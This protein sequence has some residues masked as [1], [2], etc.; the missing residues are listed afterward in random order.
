M[1]KHTFFAYWGNV[2]P[3]MLETCVAS[4]RNVSDCKIHI[5]VN[6]LPKEVE[7]NLNTYNV[8]WIKVPENKVQNRRACCKIEVL[9]NLIKQFDSDDY[10]LVSDVDIYFMKDPFVPFIQYPEMDLGLTTRGYP[11]AF[12]INGGIFYIKV[13]E[14][15][16]KWL[17]WHLDE[18]YHPVWN[19]YV[20][21]RKAW[22][23]VRY[24]LDWTV[25]QDFLIANWKERN[26]I[27]IER[28]VNIVDAGPYYNYCPP[29]DTMK[30]K[31]FEMAYKALINESV[32][33][34]H[35]KS[36]LKKMIYMPE[37]PNAKINYARGKLGWL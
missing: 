31:A 2:D 18:I 6:V 14:V 27:K 21:Q 1:N 10:V 25:N 36:E 4:L 24:G 29:T 33:V 34:L 15:M 5:A 3:N 20:I 37:F 26:A 32:A 23:H 9:H 35:L 8:N 13:N 17:D 7:T 19:P 30:S 16:R 11:H 28:N 22:N 12:P